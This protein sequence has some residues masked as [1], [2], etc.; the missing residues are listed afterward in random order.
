MILKCC[1][2]DDEH[3]AIELLE[4]YVKKTPFLQMEATYTSA[5]QALER[6]TIGDI[7]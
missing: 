6:I 4:S 2:I 1:I 5:D 7:E 3:L